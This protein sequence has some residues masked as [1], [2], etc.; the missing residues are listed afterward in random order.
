MGIGIASHVNGNNISEVG[1]SGNVTV[2]KISRPT[3]VF[4]VD[5]LLVYLSS[6]GTSVLLSGYLDGSYPSKDDNRCYDAMNITFIKFSL[7][8]NYKYNNFSVFVNSVGMRM[9][10]E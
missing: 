3:V 1:R 8:T 9:R 2:H 7:Y 4:H 10:H 5:H 6:F